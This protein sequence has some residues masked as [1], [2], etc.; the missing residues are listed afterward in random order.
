MIV[1]YFYSFSF[2]P[3]FLDLSEVYDR[4]LINV[5]FDVANEIGIEKFNAKTFDY[6]KKISLSSD[7]S[8][9][10]ISVSIFLSIF[11]NSYII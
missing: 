4:E 3:R 5:A 1:T 11:A 2:G 9:F 10:V 8:L 6:I 7:V